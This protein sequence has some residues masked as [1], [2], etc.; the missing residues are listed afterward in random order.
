MSKEAARDIRY[1]L[2]DVRQ[3][4]DRLGLTADPKSFT[5]QAS[6]LIVRCPWHDER[7]PSCSIRRG[8]DGT[9]AIRC[10]GCGATGD[11]LNLIAAVHGLTL[12]GD[13]FRQ[14]LIV[15]AEMGGLHSL[16]RELET[17]E[18]PRERPAP[19]PRPA[20]EPERDYPADARAFWDTCSPTAEV[21]EV[22]AW[23]AS[24][25]IDPELVDAG[26]LAR[27]I[28]QGA[29]V[30]PWG[31]YRGLSWS[32]TGHRLIL[33]VYDHHGALRSVRAGRVIE[34][35]SPKRLPPGGHRASGLVMACD[36]AIAM[37]QGTYRPQR[38]L[39][40]EGEPDFLTWATW[41]TR[42]AYARIALT[43]G[44]WT[45]DFA[46]RVP[47]TAKVFLCTDAD[48]A[49]DGYADAVRKTLP[50]NEIH[51]WKAAGAA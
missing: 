16:V 30:A 13:D 3:L 37:L 26:G 42:H 10:H 22:A 48:R 33:P 8:S 17:G 41:R 36:S 31:A 28:S 49:G 45:A 23:L 14:V 19:V 1:A 4:C 2:A 47:E 21:P 39:I 12:R 6:G 18:A 15:G 43:S 40:V 32:E 51:R 44:A 9:V 11:A 35:D 50:R 29:T 5:R 7:T 24:R 38:L 46:A 27:G 25:G 34:G 20:P